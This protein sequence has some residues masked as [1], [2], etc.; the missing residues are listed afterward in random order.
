MSVIAVS[1]AITGY[2]R[3][4][5][6]LRLLLSP[7]SATVVT[8]RRLSREM[9][10]SVTFPILISVLQIFLIKFLLLSHSSY[11]LTNQPSSHQPAFRCTV[12]MFQR[13]FAMS[14]TIEMYSSNIR[15][16]WQCCS[17]ARVA[18]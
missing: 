13:E 3:R 2:Y 5:R 4:L 17:E 10:S 7:A 6:C 1:V 9:Y 18:Q 11:Y 16:L 15:K 8:V 14:E 12:I